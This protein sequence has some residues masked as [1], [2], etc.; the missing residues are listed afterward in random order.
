MREFK[1]SSG[2]AWKLDLPIGTV[3]RLKTASEGGFNLFDPTPY[4]EKLA[5]DEGYFWE[6]LWHLIEPEATERKVTAEQF[7]KLMAAD[8]LLAARRLFF[9]EWLDFFQKLGRLDK[10]AV[11]QKVAEYLDKA[12]ALTQAKLASPEMSQIDQLVEHRMQ[13]SLNDSF[14]KLRASLESTP[15][16]SH[17]ES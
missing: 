10:A 17:G 15:G 5:T 14:G 3:A 4:C 16:P 1:D 12:M 7:G 9:S 8:C 11:V 13:T 2:Q 6:L